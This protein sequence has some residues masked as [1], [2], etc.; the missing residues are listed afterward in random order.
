MAA[1]PDIGGTGATDYDSPR[2]TDDDADE[3]S[4]EELKTR[5]AETAV[6]LVDLVGAPAPIVQR[7]R[8]RSGSLRADCGCVRTRHRRAEALHGM[9]HSGGRSCCSVV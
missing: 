5:R 4:I 6:G 1:T 8:T 7:S 2:K 3:D 9:G